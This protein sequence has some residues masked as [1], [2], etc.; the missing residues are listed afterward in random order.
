M[1]AGAVANL[2]HVRHAITTAR[3]VMERTSHSLIS[4]LQATSFALDMGQGLSNLS[5]P[6]SSKI[7]WD[8]CVWLHS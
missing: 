7:Y 8:W 4:G 2:R 6:T 1:A 5:T 3:L